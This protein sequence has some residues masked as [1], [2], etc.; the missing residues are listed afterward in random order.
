MLQKK[1]LL[2]DLYTHHQVQSTVFQ[3]NVTEDHAL[4]LTLYNRYKGLCEPL[5]KHT[6]N[7]FEGVI[8]RPATVCGFLK[9]E[10]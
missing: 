6:D 3:K 2:K 1:T 10:I 4:P 9:N 7:N 8:F 5:F